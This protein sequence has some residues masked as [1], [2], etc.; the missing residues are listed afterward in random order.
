MMFDFVRRRNWFYLLSLLVLVP[1]IISLIVPP[2]LKPGIEFT[3]GTTFTVRFAQSVHQDALRSALSDLGHPEAVVQRTG[4]NKFLVRT[5]ELVG[6][7]AAP[8]VGP[9][10]P[11][12]RDTI[13]AGLQQRFGDFLDN[14]GKVS[15]RF[16]DFYIVSGTVSEEIGRNAGIAVIFASVAILLYISW[17][18]R[19][20][21]KPFLFG[22]AA[23]VALL[24]DVVLVLGTFSI[25]GKVFGMEINT[26]FLT[27]LLT[28]MGFSVHDTIVVFDRIRENL[29]ILRRERLESLINKSVNQTLSRT[30]LTSGLTFLTVMALFLF[31]GEVLHGFS[32]ALVIGIIIGTYSS[33]F[34]ASPILVGWQDYIERRK[35]RRGSQVAAP[36]SNVKER[37]GARKGSARAV[38]RV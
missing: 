23:I 14:E 16:I 5:R 30:I 27:G 18:F 29:K 28:V 9:A 20:V 1:G 25:F 11:S 13:E 17:A 4:E 22:T 34:I 6:A 31:G 26:M 33:I 32:F 38:K 21:P 15:N 36:V 8:E 2:S 19:A 24:H 12:E 35:R 3:G 37:E 7:A 10:P